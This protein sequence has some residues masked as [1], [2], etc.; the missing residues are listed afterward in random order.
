[1]V[2]VF[3]TIVI[4]SSA[5]TVVHFLKRKAKEAEQSLLDLEVMVL[6]EKVCR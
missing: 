4:A 5:L 2:N 1:M 6:E 3:H